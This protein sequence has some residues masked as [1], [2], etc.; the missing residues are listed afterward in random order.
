MAQAYSGAD[1]GAVSG[2]L[3][4]RNEAAHN[5]P[6]FANRTAPEIRLMIDGVRQFIA[7]HPA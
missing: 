2:W 7:R 5:E 6:D 1:H 3:K 4:L